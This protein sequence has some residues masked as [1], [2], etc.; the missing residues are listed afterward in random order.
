MA[1]EL[2]H[3][4]PDGAPV[5]RL[6]PLHMPPDEEHDDVSLGAAEAE[7]FEQRPG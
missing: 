6:G 2:R 7:P 1:A 4:P 3:E 5:A